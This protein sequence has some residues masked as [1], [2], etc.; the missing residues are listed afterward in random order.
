MLD[1]SAYT[2]GIGFFDKV[3]ID[4][5]YRIYTDS[6]ENPLLQKL[7]DDAESA[8]YVFLTDQDAGASEADYRDTEVTFFSSSFSVFLFLSL[9]LSLCYPKLIRQKLE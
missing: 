2:A 8:G 5:G 4:Y 9:S 7:I 3:A 1:S 6:D